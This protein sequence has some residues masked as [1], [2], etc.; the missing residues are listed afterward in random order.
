MGPRSRGGGLRR[1]GRALSRFI[2]W[3]STALTLIAGGHVVT[4]DPCGTLGCGRIVVGSHVHG[5]PRSLP[6]TGVTKSPV[7]VIAADCPAAV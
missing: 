7:W 3:E 1:A 2:R 5:Q 4:P 6:A